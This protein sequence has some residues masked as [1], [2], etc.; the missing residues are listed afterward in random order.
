MRARHWDCLEHAQ[1]NTRCAF[2]QA[3]SALPPYFSSY[4]GP[5]I[6]EPVGACVWPFNKF[7]RKSAWL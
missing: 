6:T 5:P 3:L 2:K 7:R 1:D 4:Y